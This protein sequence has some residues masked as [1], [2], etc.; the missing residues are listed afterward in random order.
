MDGSTV[1]ATLSPALPA[2]AASIWTDGSQSRPLFRCVLDQQPGYL[3]P[4]SFLTGR[5]R[6]TS[7]P[8]IVSPHCRF[9]W[10]DGTPAESATAAGFLELDVKNNDA[11]R[12]G[13][14][15]AD[16]IVWVRD[17]DMQCWR[18]FWLGSEFRAL[19]ANCRAGMPLSNDTLANLSAKNIEVLR[20]ADI[21][22]SQQHEQSVSPRWEQFVT[23][24]AQGFRPHR[25]VNL[26]G[27]LHGFH[28]DALRKYYRR[29]I[30][31]GGM[32][33]GDGQT[34]RRHCAHNE[35]VSRF[36]HQQ[37]THA[38]SA[39]VGEEVKPSYTYVVSYR[40]G[41]E[42]ER[43]NDRAQCEFTLSL[44]V[45][46]PPERERQSPWPLC[47]DVDGRTVEVVQNVGDALLFCGRA[48]PH[49]RP[50]LPE[51]CTS[52]SALFHYVRKDFTGTLD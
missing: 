12:G 9:S 50:R 23:K 1:N 5:R 48:L 19:L 18:P 43:H 46:Y 41:A 4:W 38:V 35:T 34:N 27:L 29:L 28:M 33:L 36:F 2:E 30:R 25:Y 51:G 32:Y 49:F 10:V 45:D 20:Q 14:H 7:D 37:F 3:V 17:R 8:L 13:N 40:E 52:T 47:L 42:L 16:S 44:L 6:F 21:L 26:P 22:V 11:D 31:T 15:D 39:V 24:A